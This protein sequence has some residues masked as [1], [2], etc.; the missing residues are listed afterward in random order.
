MFCKYYFNYTFKDIFHC[1]ILLYK[2]LLNFL[3]TLFYEHYFHMPSSLPPK[4]LSQP[5]LPGSLPNLITKS[6]Y[7]LLSIFLYSFLSF[8]PQRTTFHVIS[9]WGLLQDTRYNSSP[10]ALAIASTASPAADAW[11]RVHVFAHSCAISL[12][13]AHS[14]C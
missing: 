9:T 2:Q 7:F 13:P 6:F 1:I 12:P 3:L 8:S 5:T 11:V 14:S 4:N 10:I